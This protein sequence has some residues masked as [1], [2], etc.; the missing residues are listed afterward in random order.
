METN[1]KQAVYRLGQLDMRE[2][3][4]QML[5]DLAGGTQGDVCTTLIDAAQRVHDLALCETTGGVAN[6]IS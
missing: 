1:E 5:L 4:V 2:A 3:A 6:G